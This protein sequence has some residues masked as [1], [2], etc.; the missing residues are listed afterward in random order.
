MKNIT[1]KEFQEKYG[2]EIVDGWLVF[3]KNKGNVDFSYNQITSLPENIKFENK[4]GVDF[5]H[6]QI[7]SLPE[8]IKFENDGYVDL[9]NN[10]LTKIPVGLGERKNLYWK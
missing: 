7:T 3:G 2:G 1:Q 10:Q 8:N 6:N 5:S 4:G 9:S